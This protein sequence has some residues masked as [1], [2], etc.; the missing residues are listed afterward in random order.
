[1]TELPPITGR[2]IRFALVGCGRISGNHFD[3]IARHGERAELVAV[4]DT[5]PAALEKAVA[6]T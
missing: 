4:C 2:R 6:K 5:D 3:A 1:M